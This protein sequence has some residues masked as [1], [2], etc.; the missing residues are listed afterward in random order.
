MGQ[1]E[2][3]I[4]RAGPGQRAGWCKCALALVGFCAEVWEEKTRPGDGSHSLK[5]GLRRRQCDRAGLA[6]PGRFLP[7]ERQE[8]LT[9]VIR[10]RQGSLGH[11]LRLPG[12]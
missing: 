6:E 8:P 5:R 12:Y 7:A 10:G 2:G 9:A 3:W 11:W 4:G 1:R